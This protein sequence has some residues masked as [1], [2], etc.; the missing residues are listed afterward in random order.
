LIANSPTKRTERSA[1][2]S[3]TPHCEDERLFVYCQV[4]VEEWF[5]AANRPSFTR[6]LQIN[7]PE[8]CPF[9]CLHLSKAQRL[10]FPRLATSIRFGEGH[11]N[12]NQTRLQNILRDAERE[13]R[14]REESQSRDSH[15]RKVTVG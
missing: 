11:A 10:A 2:T 4:I 13:L 7:D 5:R 8:R 1:S 12:H 3:G 15:S 9:P 6:M 14:T